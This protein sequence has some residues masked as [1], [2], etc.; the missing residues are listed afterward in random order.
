MCATRLTCEFC[1][2][3]SLIR[4]CWMRTCYVIDVRANARVCCDDF[5]RTFLKIW[6]AYGKKCCVRLMKITNKFKTNGMTLVRTKQINLN[7]RKSGLCSTIILLFIV[8]ISVR[9]MFDGRKFQ[10]YTELIPISS[11][12][13]RAMIFSMDY[14]FSGSCRVCL[15]KWSNKKEKTTQNQ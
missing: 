8:L 1:F 10:I 6:N 13:A 11:T 9:L 2:V 5:V 7:L 4:H 14:V 12:K 3:N 15:Q